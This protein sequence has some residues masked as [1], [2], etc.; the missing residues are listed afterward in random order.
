MEQNEPQTRVEQL[1]CL[2][3]SLRKATRTLNKLYDQS[4]ARCGLKSGQFTILHAMHY[5]GETTNKT[6]QS[7]LVLDQTTLT[8][9]LKPLIRDGYILSTPGVDR[10]E[11]NLSLSE[12]GRELHAE[13]KARWLETQEEVFSKLGAESTQH[14]LALSDSIVKLG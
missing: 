5:L 13:A 4:L 7:V 2:N 6:L 1:P 14:L 12:S 8:R 10:R 9:N 11:R 3:F